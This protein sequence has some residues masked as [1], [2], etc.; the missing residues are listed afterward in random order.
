MNTAAE[1]RAQFPQYQCHKKVRALKI[2]D[3]KP[4]ETIFHADI[5]FEGEQYAPLRVTREWYLKNL[6]RAGGYYVVYEDGYSSY[7]PAKAFEEGYKQIDNAEAVELRQVVPGTLLHLNGIPVRTVGQ[8]SLSTHPANWPLALENPETPA[9]DEKAM[10][11]FKEHTLAESLEKNWGLKLVD[12]PRITKEDIEAEIVAEY[13]FTAEQAVGDA[14]VMPAL[15]LLTFC[16]LVMRNG[17]TVVG[18]NA[19]ASPENFNAELGRKYAREDAVSQAWPLMGYEL[20]S[21]LVR[22]EA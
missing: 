20:R 9:E 8:V 15:K 19:C 11:I 2:K 4:D 12:A 18:K 3:V 10:P 22:G 6:P 16:L 1:Q 13:F 21:K 14:P 7:S 17:Y 5:T